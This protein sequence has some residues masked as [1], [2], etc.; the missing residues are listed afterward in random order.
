MKKSDRPDRQRKKRSRLSTTGYLGLIVG[1]TAVTLAT[2]TGPGGAPPKT[3]TPP[4]PPAVS[5]PPPFAPTERIDVEQAVDF[6]YD[7]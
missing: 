5:A 2:A 4:A 6:P 3:A 1:L 7:I